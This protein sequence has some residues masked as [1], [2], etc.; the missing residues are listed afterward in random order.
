VGRMGEAE[1]VAQATVM[2][3]GNSFI[4]GQTIAVNG[5]LAFL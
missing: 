4:T 5:G 2:V 1:D 3:V